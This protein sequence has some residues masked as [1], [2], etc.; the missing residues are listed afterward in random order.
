MEIGCST[1]LFREFELERAFD[2]IRSIGYE[3]TETQGVGPW[4][5]HVDIFST[6]PVQFAELAKS[7]GF[8]KVTALWMPNGNLIANEDGVSSAIRAIEWASAAGIPVVNTGDGFKDDSLADEEAYK[9]LGDKLSGILDAT[10]QFSTQLAIEPHGSFSLSLD[11]LKRI[12]SLS[13]SPRL[14]INYDAANIYRAGYVESS[15]GKSAWKSAGN[16]EDEAAVLEAVMDKVVHFHAKDMNDEQQ[17]VALG[18]GN[19]KLKECLGILKNHNYN[20]AVSVETEG[21]YSFED[22]VTLARESYEYL[23]KELR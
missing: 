2:A 22:T 10:A 17:C 19:V 6:D 7:Y 16:R 5:Q 20:G 8:K 18:R 13:D 15:H 1:V 9:I 21:G 11:G 12:M 14:G 23:V 4:C 3:Y